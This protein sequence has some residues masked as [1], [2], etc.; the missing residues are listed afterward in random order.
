MG[1][2]ILNIYSKMFENVSTK[3]VLSHVF[4]YYKGNHEQ[5][6]KRL[7]KRLFW[8][9]QNNLQNGHYSNFPYE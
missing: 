5:L 8:F 3:Y 1:I 4:K 6:E 9:I 7:I 2:L